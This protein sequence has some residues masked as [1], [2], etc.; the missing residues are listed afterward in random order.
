MPKIG[1]IFPSS[2]YLFD[3]FRGD[4]FTH[5]HLLTVLEDA[6]ETSVELA[7]ID[8]RGIKQEAVLYHIPECD[9]YLHSIY[10]LDYEEQAAIVRTLRKHYPNAVHIAGGPHANI[11]PEESLAIFDALILGEGEETIVEAIRDF[12]DS[13]LQ[14]IYRY[15]QPVDINQYPHWRR[16]FLP[17]TATA[18]KRILT[19]KR[20]PGFDEIVGTTAM[21]SRGCPYQCNFCAIREIRGELPGI[22]FRSPERI[23][24]EIE[25]LKRAY[26]IQGLALTD[27]IVIPLKKSDAVRHMEAIGKTN[28]VWR[29]QCRV[30]GITAELATL[31]AQ[32]GCVALGM[33]VESAHQKSLDIINKRVHVE[34]AKESIRILKACGIEA[35]IYLIL[36]LPGEPENIVDL[37]WSFIRETEPDLVYLSLF[38]IRPG[39]EIFRHPQKFGI[40]RVRT[41]WKKTMHMHGNQP[42]ERPELTFA[43]ER[44]TP[45]GESIPPDKI[46]DNYLELLR[47]LREA[48]LNSFEFNNLQQKPQITT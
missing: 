47:R 44:Q 2:D 28:I 12:V 25:Y 23:E 39:T 31:A 15:P 36:G 4:P 9:I 24:E 1:F 7:L 42:D 6:F 5:F 3:P 18:R 17:P 14:P 19:L 43:Y 34:R 48:N 21:F 45:W 29:G 27:E 40:A 33:G 8:L 32:S 26:K 41:D 11:F 46:V 30:D 37:T 20:R 38:T 13:R 22:R 10:T 35:R 16:H